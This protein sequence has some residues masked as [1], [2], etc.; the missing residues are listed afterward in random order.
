MKASPTLRALFYL[1]VSLFGI[2][3]GGLFPVPFSSLIHLLFV[4]VLLLFEKRVFSGEAS[5]SFAIPSLWHFPRLWLLLSPFLFCTLG[6]NLLSAKM[7]VAMGGT[8]PTVTPSLPLF[9]SAVLLSPLAEELLFRGLLLRLFRP[10][11]DA[12]A[13]ALTAVLFALAHGS[14]F[15]MPYA[16]AAGLL[17]ALVAALSRGL[18]FPICFHVFYNLLAF[19]GRDIPKASLL[20]SLG[21]LAL[22]SLVL[23]LLGERPRLEKGGE[24]PSGKQLFP[25]L[26]YAVTMTALAIFNF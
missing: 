24:K 10:F 14:L 2:V 26:L 12:W 25:L 18:A 20:W 8:V 19:F 17:L 1:L 7:T 21:G 3:L 5:P 11:G 16:L 23:F 13:I 15:Q 6:M 4:G 9:L 22:F